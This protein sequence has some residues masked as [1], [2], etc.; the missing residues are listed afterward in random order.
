MSK[1]Q[2][3]LFHSIDGEVDINDSPLVDAEIFENSELFDYL[4]DTGYNYLEEDDT[5]IVDMLNLIEFFKKFNISL[6]PLE[7]FILLEIAFYQQ[8]KCH[9]LKYSD[10]DH[11]GLMKIAEKTFN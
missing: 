8:N 3:F 2:Y 4:T 1:E 9:R 11:I 7:A 10:V 6:K 5:I